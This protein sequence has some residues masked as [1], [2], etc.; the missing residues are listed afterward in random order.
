MIAEFLGATLDI[1]YTLWFWAPGILAARLLGFRHPLDLLPLGFL[2]ST[3][4]ATVV[5][6]VAYPLVWS[7]F[8]VS[9]TRS[10]LAV[11]SIVAVAMLRGRIRDLFLPATIALV[12]TAIS[13]TVRN[14]FRL[15]GWM[16]QVDHFFT[17]WIATLMQTGDEGDLFTF[18]D[19][20]KKG[21]AFPVVL[22]MGREGLLLAV[23][24]L[25]ILTLVVLA[26]FRLT[27]IVLHGQDKRVVPF[28]LLAV[29]A[30]WASSPMFLGL[31]TYQ[32]GHGMVSLA[33]AVAVRLVVAAVYRHNPT[34]NS[35]FDASS[36][37]WSLAI[38]IF[39]ATFVMGQSRI[40][41]FALAVLV[42]LPF[43]WS[44][45]GEKTWTAF[46]PRLLAAVG[47]PLGFIVWFASIGT[48]PRDLSPAWAIFTIVLAGGIVAGGFFFLFPRLDVLARY[49]IPL[50]M[51]GGLIPYLLPLGGSR[52]NFAFLRLNTFYGEG[53]WGFTWWLIVAAMIFLLL[54]NKKTPRENLVLWLATVVI[55]FT[56][57]VKAADGFGQRW[58]SI[59]D[60]WSDSV[61]RTLFHSF[62]LV[63]TVTVAAIVS[64]I[65]RWG[66]RKP[67]G[68][69]D[70]LTQQDATS[71]QDP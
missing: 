62:S 1:A 40:E 26:T 69:P 57:L 48:T 49:S 8:S 43:L 45:Q 22:G 71:R 3:A 35:R 56:I 19:V 10:L 11:I 17:G 33:I 21:L 15:D 28:V 54:D 42:V 4:V 46:L 36:G 70:A 18:V 32:H 41:S 24:P 59:R 51:V 50:I 44:H 66:S 65:T 64:I 25:I 60:G 34:G 29:L 16:Q 47:G 23:M 30:V 67:T 31:S 14:V 2:I 38:G 58:G 39:V 5:Y 7:E 27:T 9:L 52:N 61:N 37:L 6:S 68:H 53:Y 13:A 20:Y 12:I 55:L 63:Y